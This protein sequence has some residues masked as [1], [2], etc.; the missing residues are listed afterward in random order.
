MVMSEAHLGM[1]ITAFHNIFVKN[2]M[3][4]L[5]WWPHKSELMMLLL[6]LIQWLHQLPPLP[7]PL[8]SLRNWGT[9][10]RK[11]VKDLPMWLKWNRFRLFVISFVEINKC[12]VEYFLILNICQVSC[13][14]TSYISYGVSI[15]YIQQYILN[16]LYPNSEY[17]LCGRNLFQSVCQGESVCRLHMLLK[18]YL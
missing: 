6:L 7:P 1:L 15:F 10:C 9:L 18:Q 17:F 16:V 8:N 11:N 5:I 13:M 14:I 3:L 12:H 2:I 4:L